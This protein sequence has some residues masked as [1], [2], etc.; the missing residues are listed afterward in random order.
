MPFWVA[1]D[2]SLTRTRLAEVVTPSIDC[3]PDRVMLA[4][5]ATRTESLTSR[6]PAAVAST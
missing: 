6:T 2:W 1:V 3:S 5:V 4:V